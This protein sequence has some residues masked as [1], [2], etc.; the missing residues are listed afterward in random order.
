M[1]GTFRVRVKERIG[2]EL[3]G[4]QNLKGLVGSAGTQHVS[5]IERFFERWRGE[6]MLSEGKDFQSD[7]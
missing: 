2:N 1:K 6:L 3:N 5:C 7:E 4:N